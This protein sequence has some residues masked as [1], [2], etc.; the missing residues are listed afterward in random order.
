MIYVII[1]YCG[2]CGGICIAGY[3]IGKIVDAYEKRKGR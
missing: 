1:A 3:I 2:W